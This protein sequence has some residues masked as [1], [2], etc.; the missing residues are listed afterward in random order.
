MKLLGIEGRVAPDVAVTQGTAV[1]G[2]EWTL[3]NPLTGFR[4]PR[5]ELG[6]LATEGHVTLLEEVDLGAN[7]VEERVKVVTLL[8]RPVAGL[9]PM[10]IPMVDG[11]ELIVGG[12]VLMLLHAGWEGART[13]SR[14]TRDRVLLPQLEAGVTDDAA[15]EIIRVGRTLLGLDGIIEAWRVLTRAGTDPP[16]DVLEARARKLLG[17]V[18]LEAFDHVMRTC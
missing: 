15:A 12:R 5:R 16:T 3:L 2:D 18:E 13:W 11:V 10:T 7:G 8:Q 14:E 6:H 17:P 4:Q 1:L 9:D